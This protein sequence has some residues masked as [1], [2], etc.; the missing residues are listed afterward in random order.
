MQPSRRPH[1]CHSVCICEF[2]LGYV[3][4][5]ARLIAAARARGAQTAARGPLKARLANWTRECCSIP[6][7]RRFFYGLLLFS[8]YF[9]FGLVD[10]RNLC[11]LS[12]CYLMKWSTYL[13][14]VLTSLLIF[15]FCFFLYALIHRTWR[16]LD[17]IYSKNLV[18]Y[19]KIFDI[20]VN[21]P[22][23]ENAIFLWINLFSILHCYGASEKFLY[24]Q[25]ITTCRPFSRRTSKNFKFPPT[26]ETPRLR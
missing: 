16:V 6:Q 21:W 12:V 7:W 10:E 18:G 20:F 1:I 13:W 25:S 5:Y 17:L 8:G 3:L 23:F 14:S 11:C 2:C 4:I 15:R 24:R 9:L 19:L 22:R 26:L